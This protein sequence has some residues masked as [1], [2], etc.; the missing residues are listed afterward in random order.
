M[1]FN[2]NWAPQYADK[3]HPTPGLEGGPKENESAAFQTW[4]ASAPVLPAGSKEYR[5]RGL[6]ADAYKRG[7]WTDLN[8]AQNGVVLLRVGPRE[9][10]G[11]EDST[12]S[13]KDDH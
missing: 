5:W 11:A 6:V 4:Y 1:S 13:T 12:R 7:L 2:M 10:T 3:A 9:D 8:V